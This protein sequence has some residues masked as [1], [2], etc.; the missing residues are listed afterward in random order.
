M[1]F[2]YAIEG[3]REM[4]VGEGFGFGKIGGGRGERLERER[5][6]GQKRDRGAAMGRVGKEST[7][8]ASSV[9]GTGHLSQ[10]LA[11]ISPT[12]SIGGCG[13][14]RSA[15][16]VEGERDGEWGCDFEARVNLAPKF[17][18]DHRHCSA[19]SNQSGTMGRRVHVCIL[20]CG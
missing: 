17:L 15:K 3:D 12:E 19:T 1:W 9:L 8:P 13:G 4:G 11:S 20:H 7:H 16:I 14:R 6:G 10:L 2:E 5:S 18:L